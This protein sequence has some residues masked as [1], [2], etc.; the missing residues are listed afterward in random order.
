MKKRILCFGDSN[1]YG[2]IARGNGRRYGENIRWPSRLAKMLGN[3]YTVIEEGLPG[4]TTDT[5][6]SQEPWKNGLSV[7]KSVLSSHRPIDMM[8]LMLGTN[9]LK[10]SFHREAEPIDA[11]IRTIID[12]TKSFMLEK[13]NYSPV[14]L[15]IA[16]APLSDAAMSADVMDFDEHSVAVSRQLGSS[17]RRTAEEKNILFLDAADYVKVSET[18]GIHLDADNHVLLANAVYTVLSDWFSGH[19][20]TDPNHARFIEE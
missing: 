12:D 5:A 10:A 15:L 2:Y 14:I 13:Q 20:E 6:L 11:G 9:D 17:F 4:R 18:D 1:T 3:D 19:S 8:I 16:P 7:L